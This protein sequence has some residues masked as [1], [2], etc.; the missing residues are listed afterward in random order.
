MEL[1]KG[2]SHIKNSARSREK[3]FFPSLTVMDTVVFFAF[4]RGET[5]ANVNNPITEMK[6]FG[7]C[8]RVSHILGY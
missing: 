3:F 2:K 1:K 6:I 8:L 7:F 4:T 5:S